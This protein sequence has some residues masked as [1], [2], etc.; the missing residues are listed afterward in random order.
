MAST[1]ESFGPSALEAMACGTAVVGTRVGGLPEVVEDGVS[2]S[3]PWGTSPASPHTWRRSEDRG[4]SSAMG[5]AARERATA[6][7]DR[8]HVVGQYES[9]Y[10]RLNGAV[11]SPESP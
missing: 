5:A 6:L 1:E 8:R 11:T 2:A 9:L 7:F 3:P 10:R 4:R